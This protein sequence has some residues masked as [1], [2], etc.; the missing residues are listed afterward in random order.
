MADTENQ[1]QA[2]LGDAVPADELNVEY[3]YVE[4]EEGQELPDGYEYEYVEVPSENAAEPSELDVLGNHKV[5]PAME[6]PTSDYIPSQDEILS[7]PQNTINVSENNNSVEEIKFNRPMEKSVNE[8]SEIKFMNEDDVSSSIL[9]DEYQNT[10]LQSSFQSEVG[11]SRPQD[12]ALSDYIFADDDETE[13]EVAEDPTESIISTV[14]AQAPVAEASIEADAGELSLEDM[15]GEVHKPQIDHSVLDDNFGLDILPAE[16]IENSELSDQTPELEVIPEVENDASVSEISYRN[17]DITSGEKTENWFQENENSA[18]YDPSDVHVEYLGKDLSIEENN[19]NDVEA[20][21]EPEASFSP[22]EVVAFD[23]KTD[24]TEIETPIS[25]D[26]EYAEPTEIIEDFAENGIYETKAVEFSED[27]VSEDAAYDYNGE[28]VSTENEGII[29]VSED[30]ET[31]E[32]IVASENVDQLENNTEVFAEDEVVSDAENIAL[33]LEVDENIISDV[34]DV[35][36]QPDNTLLAET[37]NSF[38]VAENIYFVAEVCDEEEYKQN[39]SSAKIVNKDG[40]IQSFKG[41]ETQDRIVLDEIDFE[42][43]ELKAWNMILFNENIFPLNDKVSNFSMPNH[44]NIARYMTLIKQGNK[45]AELFNEDSLQIINTTDACVA[46]DGR[47]LC[48]DFGENSGVVINDF[49]AFS[50]NDFIGCKICF[51]APVA[52]LL[53]GPKGCLV[54][55]FNVKQII[56]PKNGDMVNSGG[57]R[58]V[59][60]LADAQYFNFDRNSSE[61]E[62]V[63]NGEINSIL[64]NADNSSHGWKVVF[65]SGLSMSLEELRSFQRQYGQLPSLKGVIYYGDKKLSF[66]NV[67]RIDFVERPQ[68]FFYT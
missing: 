45:K 65:D 25:D 8:T 46:V 17:Q 28:E 34:S 52:G 44:Q 15:L 7:A 20:Y 27:I 30:Y 4:L 10:G 48:G 9:L 22:S 61:V 33:P 60:E 21:L 31:S 55:F 68:Y 41:D 5:F 13:E 42:N 23:E 43:H 64:V 36:V 18:E 14:T 2:N 37:S 56:L 59:Q 16:E 12:K 66:E 38:K 67:K 1:V 53:T 19:I 6:N 63:G 54:F 29:P 51:S 58:K 24:N 57:A 50:L 40:G 26:V 32:N 49:A 11:R 3:E 62:F 35:S 39:L 47:F